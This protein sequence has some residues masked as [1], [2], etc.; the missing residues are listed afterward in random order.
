MA[1]TIATSSTSVR[2]RN[3]RSAP[4]TFFQTIAAAGEPVGPRAMRVRGAPPR[5]RR[6]SS[7]RPRRIASTRRATLPACSTAASSNARV[8]RTTHT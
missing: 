8:D 2:T 7:I 1:I 3:S 4:V 5:G 6:D